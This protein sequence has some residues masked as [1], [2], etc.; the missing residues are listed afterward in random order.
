MQDKKFHLLFT[1]SKVDKIPT[2]EAPI[3][4]IQQEFYHRTI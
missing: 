2:E 1:I 3:E 4:H